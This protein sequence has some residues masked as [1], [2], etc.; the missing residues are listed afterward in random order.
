MARHPALPQAII[1]LGIEKLLFGK[2]VELK[3]MIHIRREDKIVLLFQ[4]VQKN[5]VQFTWRQVVAIPID[6]SAPIGPFLFQRWKGI[7]P[8]RIHIAEMVFG[9]KI[10]EMTLKSITV[11]SISGGG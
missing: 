10:S 7:E 9:D 1:P 5:S 6:L 8:R 3:Q 11:V 4:Q 2:A